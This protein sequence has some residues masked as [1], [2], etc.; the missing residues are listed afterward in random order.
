MCIRDRP[1]TIG[2][3]KFPKKIP[4]LNHNLFKGVR[5]FE[6]IRPKTKNIIEIIKTHILISLPLI[7]GQNAI[8]PNTTAKTIPKLLLEP[9][10]MFLVFNLYC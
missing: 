2:A 8:K 10:L 1:I 4:N 7:K 6:L 5:I 3:I 9:I